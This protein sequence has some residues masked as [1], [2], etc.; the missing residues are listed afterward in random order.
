[1]RSLTSEAAR[2]LVNHLR[3]PSR[4][5]AMLT[6][7][8]A[9]GETLSSRAGVWSSFQRINERG[10]GRRGGGGRRAAFGY[11]IETFEVHETS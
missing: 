11:L 7:H 4:S 9:A 8:A 3:S 5:T 2:P 1:M 10:R 6:F